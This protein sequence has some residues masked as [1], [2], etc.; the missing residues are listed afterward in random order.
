MRGL[1]SFIWWKGSRRPQ[2]QIKVLSHVF[3]VLTPTTFTAAGHGTQ[4]DSTAMKKI[5]FALLSIPLLLS[6]CFP[7][8]LG[9]VR[10]VSPTNEEIIKPG[11]KEFLAQKQ[12]ISVVLRTPATSSSVTQSELNTSNTYYSLIEKRLMQA[13]MEVRDR[14]LLNS[15][16]V[17]GTYDY[18][19]ISQKTN[20]DII[21][22]V[23]SIKFDNQ[24]NGE[25]TIK[26]K[27]QRTATITSESQKQILIE[28]AIIDF[29]LI[30]IDKGEPGILGTFYYIGDQMES[31]F[32]YHWI[33]DPLVYGANQLS[34]TNNYSSSYSKIT[35]YS[36]DKTEAIDAFAEYLIRILSGN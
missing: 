9:Y 12:P 28:T 16:L 20:A 19:E 25:V 14:G 6:S 7:N 24:P 30:R 36:K 18:N 21:I 35:L 26:K 29:K 1:Y 17:G 22:E 4:N 8:Y 2:E 31:D 11:F 33:S 27:D 15:L 13:G 10:G 23:T 32:Y 3:Y 5:V 34:W